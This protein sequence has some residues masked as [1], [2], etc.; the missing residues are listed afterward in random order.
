[1]SSG[2]VLARHDYFSRV[3]LHKKK[4]D[5]TSDDVDSHKYSRSLTLTAVVDH[6]EISCIN[7]GRSRRG[8]NS[9]RPGVQPTTTPAC[10]VKSPLGN[11]RSAIGLSIINCHRVDRQKYTCIYCKYISARCGCCWRK[12]TNRR[13]FKTCQHRS[14]LAKQGTRSTNP[15]GEPTDARPAWLARGGWGAP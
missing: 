1:M 6:G 5:F 14:Y 2:V 15:P 10:L 9:K 8:K 11:Q 3:C 13:K 12:R 4:S 7:T